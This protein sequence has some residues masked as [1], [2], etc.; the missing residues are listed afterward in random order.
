MRRVAGQRERLQVRTQLQGCLNA[1]IGSGFE[2][3]RRRP[4]RVS[5][6][7]SARSRPSAA[8]EIRL[9]FGG[10]V[11]GLVDIELRLRERDLGEAHVE[12]RSHRAL[13][14]CPDLAQRELAII[15]RRLGGPSA[16]FPPSA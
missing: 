2:R 7:V 4:R 16:A 6:N 11:F 8:A 3:G 9:R 10:N 13:L 14:Q 1:W 5:V 12:R 15:H